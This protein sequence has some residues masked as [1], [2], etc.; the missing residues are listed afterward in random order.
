MYQE[1]LADFPFNVPTIVPAGTYKGQDKDIQTIKGPS[2]IC[3][4][5]DMPD[6][7]VVKILDV[8]LEKNEELASINRDAGEYKAENATAL[9]D[10]MGVPF[11]RAAEEYWKSKGVF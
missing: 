6:E 7:L 8:I 4:R 10:V 11:H 3:V 5:D 2:Y 9:M 1:Y